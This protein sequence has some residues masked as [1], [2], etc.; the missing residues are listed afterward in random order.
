MIAPEPL[1][2]G[3]TAIWVLFNL[4]D[5]S[6]VRSLHSQRAALAEHGDLEAIDQDH[7]ILIVF[8]GGARRLAA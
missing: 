3:R 5:E 6:A 7:I 4:R 1:Y 8:P 2:P